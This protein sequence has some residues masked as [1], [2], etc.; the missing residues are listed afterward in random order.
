M[1]WIGWDVEKYKN[2]TTHRV[3]E[4]ELHQHDCTT[5]SVKVMWQSKRIGIICMKYVEIDEFVSKYEP[6]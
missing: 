5:L 4:A 2:K 3:V 6:A 1:G